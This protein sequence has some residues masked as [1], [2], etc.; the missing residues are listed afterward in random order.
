MSIAVTERSDQESVDQAMKTYMSL[1]LE[2]K[3]MFLSRG[4]TL[5]DELFRVFFF[6]TIFLNSTTAISVNTGQCEYLE[7][8]FVSFIETGRRPVHC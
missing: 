7:F 2:V 3:R 1:S 8:L 4:M 6:L 5:E